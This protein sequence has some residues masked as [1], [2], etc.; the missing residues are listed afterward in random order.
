MTFSNSFRLKMTISNSIWLRMI[1]KWDRIAS[2]QI[3]VVFGT[4]EKYINCPLP[5]K[6]IKQKIG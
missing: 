5:F 4:R 1:K 3:S 2:L 6:T